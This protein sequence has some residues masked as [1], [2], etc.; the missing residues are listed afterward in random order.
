MSTGARALDL[1]PLPRRVVDVFARCIN[2]MRFMWSTV[3]RKNNES[4]VRAQTIGVF[5]TP[6]NMVNVLKFIMLSVLEFWYFR[7]MSHR[8]QQ[9]N[10]DFFCLSCL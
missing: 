2:P 4:L 9:L 3:H 5:G 6:Q 8:D 1:L 7:A 10:F